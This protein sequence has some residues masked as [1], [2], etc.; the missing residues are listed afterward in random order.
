MAVEIHCKGCGHKL[1]K[2]EKYERKYK[3]PIA[4]C[5][6]CG[7]DYIDPRCH[8]LAIEGIPE[9]DFKITN[10]IILLVIGAL[11][12]WRG[13]YLFGLRMLGTPDAMQ[14]VLPTVILLLGIAIILGGIVDFI[15]II[16]GI[17]RRKYEKDLK[18]SKERI[19]NED[20]IQKLRDLGY[21]R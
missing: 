5:K 20:Y 6:K 8:E 1:L 9:G 4:S 10:D 13:Y 17:K 11:I 3:S 21:I 12:A 2:Y 15:R 14:W 18:E 16:T 7:K 19:S